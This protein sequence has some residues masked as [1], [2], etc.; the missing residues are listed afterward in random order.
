IDEKTEVFV[1]L[2][3]KMLDEFGALETGDPAVFPLLRET[4]KEI[5]QDGRRTFVEGLIGQK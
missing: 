3:V 2:L 1:P 5:G 4:L